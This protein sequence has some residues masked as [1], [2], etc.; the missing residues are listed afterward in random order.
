MKALLV[1]GPNFTRRLAA[2]MLGAS[3]F[4]PAADVGDNISDKARADEL[5]QRCQASLSRALRQHRPSH[6]V[7][8][9]N[10]D[11]TTWR[12]QL[13]PPYKQK[14]RPT[15]PALPLAMPRMEATFRDLGVAC[16]SL[17]GQPRDDVLATAARKIAAGGGRAVLLSTDRYFCQLLGDS[18]VVFDHFAQRALDAEEV[19]A[20]SG[21]APEHLV[22][23]LA[24]AGVSGLSIPG[25]RGIGRRTAAKLI[26]R[27]GGVD[28][29][30]AAAGSSLGSKMLR[31]T[32]D[33]LNRG[34]REA[35][36]AKTLFTLKTDLDL[37]LNLNQFRYQPGVAAP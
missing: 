27:Y 5:L 34:Q 23:A 19:M 24:L 15:P 21:V 25:V 32:R 22:D 29:I 28:D 17:P 37:G 26:A 1:D 35:R 9:F 12:H 16:F 4:A 7:V 30:L 31:G 13:H 8:V 33:K 14:S 18:I 3:P 10:G 6:C 20:R 36:L 2:A 11:G